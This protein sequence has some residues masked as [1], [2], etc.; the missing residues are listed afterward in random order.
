MSASGKIRVLVVDD[1]ALVRKILSTSLGKDPQIEVV[2]PAA[3]PYRARDLLVELRP[4]VIT[5]DVEMPRMD[6]VT[7]LKRFM[8]IMPVPT[9]VISS[10]TQAGKRITLE[11]L[12]AGAVDVMAKPTV[13]LTSGLPL[14]AEESARG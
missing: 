11:A 12:E 13:D 2:G 10:L 4:D 1:S 14:M 5:L 9:V 3:D 6:G 8:P 7:F